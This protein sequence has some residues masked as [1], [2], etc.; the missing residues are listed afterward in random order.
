[1]GKSEGG[2][3]LA[4]LALLALLVAKGTAVLKIHTYDLLG[5]Y[6]FDN[7]ILVSGR[8]DNVSAP[9]SDPTPSKPDRIR[10]DLSELLCPSTVDPSSI[11]CIRK[12]KE[13]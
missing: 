2:A 13:R 1:M 9:F 8:I 3:E 6:V 4:E 10:S 7:D 12:R 5:M 11:P